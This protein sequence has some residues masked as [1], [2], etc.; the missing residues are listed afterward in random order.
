MILGRSTVVWMSLITVL[1]QFLNQAV[2]LFFPDIDKE[3]LNTL[4]NGLTGV[5][6]AAIALIAKTSTTPISDPRLPIGT[7]VNG[8]SAAPTGVVV[9]ED[10]PRL[11]K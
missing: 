10:D 4:F 5:V 11:A 6:A 2:P 7:I 1:L 8:T 3:A 9:A